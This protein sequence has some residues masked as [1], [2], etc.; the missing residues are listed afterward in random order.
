MCSSVSGEE[1]GK[2]APP[3]LLQARRGGDGVFW[4]T[5]NSLVS[6][7]GNRSRNGSLHRVGSR[8]QIVSRRWNQFGVSYGRKAE[9]TAYDTVR[10]TC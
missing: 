1:T 4:E 8:N 5:R 10:L 3:P 9:E 2:H 6:L 7:L